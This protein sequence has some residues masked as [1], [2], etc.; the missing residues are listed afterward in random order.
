MGKCH[1]FYFELQ[2]IVNIAH[3]RY[4]LQILKYLKFISSMDYIFSKKSSILLFYASFIYAKHA[5]G[6]IKTDQ[7]KNQ[8]L[9]GI[10]TSFERSVK[11]KVCHFVYI[12]LDSF[13]FLVFGI[14]NRTSSL[15]Y[16]IKTL[17][18]IKN[19]STLNYI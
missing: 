8:Y 16:T 18:S 14:F 2:N 7:I 9:I 10:I 6:L 4:S 5:F 17:V 3:S 13:H 19:R 12:K 15:W 11:P 1:H